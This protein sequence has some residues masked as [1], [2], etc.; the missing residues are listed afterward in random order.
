MRLQSNVLLQ[1]GYAGAMFQVAKG[2]HER[3]TSSKDRPE[4]ESLAG[5]ESD[6][7]SRC[8]ALQGCQMLHSEKTV[9]LEAF[10]LL[11]PGGLF[12]SIAD[13]LSLD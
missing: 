9:L 2:L 4:M 8:A 3:L 7:S 6:F 5:F 12:V 1:K 10:R 11:Q 13:V